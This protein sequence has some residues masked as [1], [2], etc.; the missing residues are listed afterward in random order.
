[1]AMVVLLLLILIC[2]GDC[3]VHAVNV[4]RIVITVFVLMIIIGDGNDA[5]VVPWR[6]WCNYRVE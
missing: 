3:R 6:L 5:V 2:G 1:M 4:E